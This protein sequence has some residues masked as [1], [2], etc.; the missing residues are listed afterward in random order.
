MMNNNDLIQNIQNI[1]AVM[2]DKKESYDKFMINNMLEIG[3]I[4]YLLDTNKLYY[5]APDFS[6]E[7]YNETLEDIEIGSRFM[8]RDNVIE[9]DNV[10]M[11]TNQTDGYT[12][13]CIC[14]FS[15]NSKNIGNL[16]FFANNTIVLPT[17]EKI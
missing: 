13:V 3:Q 16:R 2:F 6:L 5:V 8:F 7:L 14:L 11:K 1:K 12:S 4:V 17:I 10:Y 15:Y 9:K